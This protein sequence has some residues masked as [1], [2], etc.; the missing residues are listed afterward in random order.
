MDNY[1]KMINWKNKKEAFKI[2]WQLEYLVLYSRFVKLF[3]INEDEH[4]KESKKLLG[5]MEGLNILIN[6]LILE[7]DNEEVCVFHF[8]YLIVRYI[9]VK[10]VLLKSVKSVSIELEE[11]S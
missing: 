7:D 8:T 5:R 6:E 2:K 9:G 1:I 11:H 10:P 4:Q 3:I